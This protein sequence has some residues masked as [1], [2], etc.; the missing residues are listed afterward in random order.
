MVVLLWHNRSRSLQRVRPPNWDTAQ[1]GWGRRTA[2]D[3]LLIGS[4]LDVLFLWCAHGSC[5]ILVWA[6]VRQTEDHS[7][8]FVLQACGLCIILCSEVLMNHSH[9]VGWAV[10]PRKRCLSV[11]HLRSSLLDC[12]IHSHTQSEQWITLD[13]SSAWGR[14]CPR[15]IMFS[16]RPELSA[17]WTNRIIAV[18]SLISTSWLVLKPII[19][20]MFAYLHQN[21][22]DRAFNVSA[23]YK[24]LSNRINSLLPFL[25]LPALSC[26]WAVT[27]AIRWP[28]SHWNNSA[29]PPKAPHISS[30]Q[31]L[32]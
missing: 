20:V 30:C 19:T 22:P 25:S 15:M 28:L 27:A 18:Q 8:H 14:H 31:G 10:V 13:P 29:C 21:T 7:D 12:Y 23:Y 2:W 1:T 6:E 4:L 32:F 16:W 17:Y 9:R 26:M 24:S 5:H 11:Q 3:P